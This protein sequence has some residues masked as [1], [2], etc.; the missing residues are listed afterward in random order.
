MWLLERTGPGSRY[1]QVPM[2][3]SSGL[4]IT[5]EASSQDQRCSM[6]QAL[7]PPQ[8]ASHESRAANHNPSPKIFAEKASTHRKRYG[9]VRRESP[10]QIQPSIPPIYLSSLDKE[11]PPGAA[12]PTR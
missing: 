5:K 7:S 1:I 2:S 3:H 4:Q 9:K 6:M 8:W 12:S 10:G 11:N